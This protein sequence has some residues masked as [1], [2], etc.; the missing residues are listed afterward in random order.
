MPLTPSLS[1]LAGRGRGPRSGRVRGR[2]GQKMQKRGLILLA[3]ATLVLVVMAV[4][5][6]ATGDRTVNR[7]GPGE[8]AFPALAASLGGVGSV[9]LKRGTVES[10]IVSDS[11]DW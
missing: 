10:R 2:R 1:P 5:A 3:A 11:H 4:V 8:A 7:A 9:G 6:I